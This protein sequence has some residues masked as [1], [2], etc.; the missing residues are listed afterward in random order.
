[1]KRGL[2]IVNTRIRLSPPGTLLKKILLTVAA[3]LLFLLSFNG[4][5]LDLRKFVQ[6]LSNLGPVLSRMAH[7]DLSILPDAFLGM[8]TSLTL[9]FVSLCIGALLSLILSFLAASNIAPSKLLAGAIKG[10]VAVIRA[11]PA[12]VWVLMVVASMGFGNTGGMIGLIFPVVGY[13][14]K[15]FTAS[16]EELGTNLIEAP[17]STGA[18]WLAIVLKCLLP[19][20]LPAFV[21]WIAIR[22]EGNMAESISLGMVGVSGIGALLNRSIYQYNYA[23]TTTLILVIF[24]SMFL[25]EFATGALK[26]RITGTR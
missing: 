21:S 19:T 9:A 1:M 16:I 20:V 17:R 5:G 22:L 15:S 7:L 14:T 18:P 23:V 8:L 12:L 2:E 10:V 11:V 4:L 13:L 6:R 3:A 24:L 25:L 26:R